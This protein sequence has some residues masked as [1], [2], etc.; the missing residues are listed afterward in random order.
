MEPNI[1]SQDVRLTCGNRRVSRT[2]RPVRLFGGRWVVVNTNRV[3]MAIAMVGVLISNCI[4]Y[5]SWTSGV[6]FVTEREVTSSSVVFH[7]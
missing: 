2:K 1:A 6:A 5:Q 3:S 4:S 7:R